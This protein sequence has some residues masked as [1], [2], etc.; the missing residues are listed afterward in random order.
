MTFGGYFWL[1]SPKSVEITDVPGLGLSISVLLRSIRANGS[2]LFSLWFLSCVQ[3]PH[4]L[5]TGNS[6]MFIQIRGEFI[7][8]TAIVL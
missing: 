1:H 4:E 5:F 2:D 6:F 3:D 7:Q 8:L